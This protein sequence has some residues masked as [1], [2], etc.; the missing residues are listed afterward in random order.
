[1]NFII[2]AGLSRILTAYR[3]KKESIPFKVL[4]AITRDGGRIN[5]I[6]RKEISVAL[7]LK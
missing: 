4:E 7:Q 3:L 5:G 2:G 1:M 6:F